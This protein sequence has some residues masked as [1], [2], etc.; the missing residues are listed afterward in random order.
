MKKLLLVDGTAFAYRAFYAIRD[1]STKDGRPTNA[2]FGF[3]RLLDQL[4]Q[5]W[6]PSHLCVL[7]DGGV[8]AERR[9]LLPEYKA[10]RPPMPTGLSGQLPLISEYLQCSNIVQWRV[11][12]QEA[13]DLIAA[14]VAK[15]EPVMDRILIATSDKDMM[16]LVSDKVGIVAPTAASP[17]VLDPAGVEAKMGVPPRLI[18]PWLALIGDSSDNIPGVPGVGPKTATKWLN[19][20][21]S[22]DNLAANIPQLKPEKWRQMLAEY[23]PVVQKNM[24]LVQLHAP[25][26]VQVPDLEILKW[27][28][29]NDDK[30]YEFCTRYEL[31]SLKKQK[32]QCFF[33]FDN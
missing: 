18:A 30:A 19:D 25:V 12:G 5:T 2:L 31:H 10:Q 32:A 29:G 22:L 23:W 21:G 3:I 8:P 17:D 14:L 11:E 27:S 16:Q 15:A 28:P 1:L 26:G 24:A 9:Q 13:D 20:Y 4:L 7:F 33:S 6:A